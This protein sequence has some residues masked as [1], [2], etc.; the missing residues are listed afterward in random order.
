VR[1]LLA[2]VV[3]LASL[4]SRPAAAQVGTTTDIIT[5]TVT[6]PDSQPL[7]GATVLATSVETRVSRQR[8]TDVHGRFTIVFPDGGGRYEL[9]ARFVGMAPSQITIAREADE[10]R[11]VARIHMGLLS[12]ALEPVTVTARSNVRSDRSGPGSS[13]RSFNPDQLTRLP[14]DASDP[15][16]IATLQP[17]VLGTGGD[18]SSITTN[19]SVA[20]QRPT[21]NNVTLDGV[22][23][24]SGSVPQD[25]VRSI[26]VVTNTYDVA[27][28]QFSGG[29]IASTTRSG[30]NIPQGS[31]TYS[32]RDR[33]LA[34]G[35]VTT[36]A[37]GQ[38]STQNQLSGGIGGP[39]VSNKLFVFG[40]LQGRWRGDALPSLTTADAGTLVRLGVSPDS[41]A[42]FVALAA[43]S[44]APTSLPGL[45]PD[46]ST[47]T[48][49]ALLRLDWQASDAQT[50]TLR[51]DGSWDSQDPTRVGT[52]AVPAT[53][54]TRSTR[55]DGI[56]ASLTSFVGGN[57]INELR[58]YFGRDRRVARGYFALPAAH[59]EVASDLP[60]SGQGV[61]TLA[62]GG[63]SGL[64]QRIDDQGLEVADEFSWLSG[65]TAH[66]LK[67]GVD[68]V[69][70]RVEENQVSNQL[71]T[72]V[73]PSLAALAADSPSMFTRTLAP[74]GRAGTAW[75][76]ALYAGDAWRP[77]AGLSLTYGMRFEAGRFTGAPSYNRAVDSL[78][79][80]RTDR[81]PGEVHVSPRIGFTWQLGGAGRTDVLHSTYLRGGLGDFRSPTPTSLYATALSA[82]GTA[83]AQTELVCVGAAVPRPDWSRYA[84]DP[85][86]I[87]LQCAD[88]AG[89]VTVTPQPAVTAFDAGYRAP[90]ARRASLAL[91]QRFAA[92]Y[93]VTL[94]ASYAR[95]VHQYGF[96]D[97]N[98]T[99]VPR[100]TL[101]DEAGR[102]VYVPADSIVS[103]TGALS[104]TA[105]RV[106]PEFRQVLVIGSDLQSDTKQLT[107]SFTGAT[108]RGAAFRVAYT[109]M[110]A[111]DQSSFSCCSAAS[112]FASPTTAGNP[113]AR[114]W[115]TSNY[116]RRHSFVGTASYPITRA[117]EITAYGRFVSG[118]P[119]TPLVGSD[120]NGDG[121]RND[122]AFLFDPATAGDTSVAS[123]MRALLAGAPSAVRSCL[124]RQLGRIAARNSCTGPWQPS[125]D[126]Q[127]NWRPAWFALDRRLT[128][129]VLTVNLLGGLD[130]WLHGAANLHGWG[131]GTWPDP[132][133]LYVNGFDP[134]AKSFHYTVNGRFGSVA[135]TSGG[136]T[137]PFQLALQ[138]RYALGPGR[139]RQRARAAAT[140]P[141]VEAPTLPVNLVAAIL[142]LRDSLACTPEQVTQLAAISDS[143]DARDR[144]LADSMQAVVQQ[145]GDRTDPA[146]VLARLGPL[147]AAARDNVRQALARARAVLTP[148][149][150]SKV[151]EALK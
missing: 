40:A 149:Q 151:P 52:L 61:T 113:D 96:R 136:I 65:R 109:F 86:T 22:S 90:A 4:A 137:L 148:E 67:L 5:G 19:F 66:R 129:S 147:V 106:H 43:A 76:S 36:S 133:L 130:Q 143:L 93:W 70:T 110:R 97:L 114:E 84:Q 69:G 139:V 142:Q 62:F 138:G 28:G 46:R 85:A 103:A 128:L 47:T 121:A 73:F 39:I 88:T 115:A 117:L 126:L 79:G 7:A 55:G 68:V 132:V 134:A 127:L 72:F 64:P 77:A 108:S 112:G 44:G 48:T 30:T 91:V 135:S 63:N 74:A 98:R 78:F 27:R 14:I 26:R 38:G 15:A 18:S 146:I 140:T 12:V 17:G 87:P 119:F 75:N 24:G 111:S 82:P 101:S 16:A 10:D 94:D 29:L 2:L 50:L 71:G 59:V 33:S 32:L 120:L 89:A 25:A 105:S 58:G 80:V 20:G 122:R 56:F 45:S 102:A 54:G 150:W 37:F 35:E 124:A 11:I 141:A 57:F 118:A 60:D 99:T 34:W 125:F 23:F 123:G 81:V 53:G 49:L 1:G 13:D 131:Y 6:G 21:A 9:T 3:L 95:G 92:N 83:D 41:A 107:L 8:V 145:A 51:L 104:S 31:F 116:E 100:F 42:R 144:T